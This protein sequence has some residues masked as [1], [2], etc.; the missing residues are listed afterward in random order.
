MGRNFYSVLGVPR[1]APQDE[2][3]K[4][5]KKQAL[6]F[7]PDK[8]KSPG[9]AERFKEIAEAYNVLTDP[10]QRQIFDDYGEEGLGFGFAEDPLN[11]FRDIFG[12]EDPFQGTNL[13]FSFHYWHEFLFP[14]P[15]FHVFQCGV[16]AF[17]F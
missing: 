8:N 10:R 7:H 6:M 12:N 16:Y 14:S 2:I 3:K 1:N 15:V 9:A 17:I 13:R 11:V 5:Y 4:A